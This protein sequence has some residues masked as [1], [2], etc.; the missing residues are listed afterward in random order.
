ML[1][2]KVQRC[3]LSFEK[4]FEVFKQYSEMFGPAFARI[5]PGHELEGAMNGHSKNI[6]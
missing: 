4:L 3:P 5:N 1:C 2:S 6:E